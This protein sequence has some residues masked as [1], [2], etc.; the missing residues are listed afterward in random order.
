MVSRKRLVAF[1]Q[2]AEMAWETVVFSYD[3]NRRPIRIG[4]FDYY[5]LPLR[6]STRIKIFRYYRQFWSNRYANRMICSA[7]FKK[8]RGRLYSPDADTGG[9]PSRVLSLTIINQ[10]STN[11]ILDAILGLPGDSIADGETVRY[12]ILRNP[13]TEALT[14]KLRRSR[15]ADYRYDPCKIGRRKLKQRKLK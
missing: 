9:L 7:G 12:F 13:S 2:N 3:P 8:I 10:T 6:F 1:I 5:R 11:I 4:D 14:I 15:F